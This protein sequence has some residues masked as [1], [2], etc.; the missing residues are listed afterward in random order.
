MYVYDENGDETAEMEWMLYWTGMDIQEVIA[1]LFPW[2]NAHIDQGFYD[3]HSE[4]KTSLED[5]RDA[6]ADI[7]NE[8]AEPGENDSLDDWYP[9]ADNGE[10]A[11]Y[12]FELTLNNL[13]AAYL[14]VADYLEEARAALAK[15]FSPTMHLRI[16]PY[17]VKAP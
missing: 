3:I 9:Y 2:S 15:H 11:T 7:D 12:R 4:F 13:G 8:I 1:R 14:T 17:A 6:A 16:L 5:E 10:T